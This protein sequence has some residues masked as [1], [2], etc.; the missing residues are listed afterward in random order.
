V[1]LAALL[2]GCRWVLGVI[3]VTAGAAKI[4]DARS[5]EQSIA[6]YGLVP[7]FLQGPVARSL[8]VLEICLGAALVLGVLPTLA[9]WVACLLLVAF[10]SGVGWNLARGR[11]FDCGCGTTRDTPISVGLVLRDLALATIA[12]AVA[13]GPSGALAVWRG[14]SALPNHAPPMSEL[15]PIPMLAILILGVVRSLFTNPS[16]W[17]G[18]QRPRRLGDHS[19]DRLSIVQVHGGASTPAK[20]A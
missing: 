19:G 20:V 1:I 16:V 9:G 4:G 11:R 12:A 8:P 7:E 18:P 15:I 3:F 14:S 5:L 6:A 17:H 2:L 13:L 10:A